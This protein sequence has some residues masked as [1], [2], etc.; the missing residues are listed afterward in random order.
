MSNSSPDHR[1]SILSAFYKI[2]LLQ[3]DSDRSCHIHLHAL[4]CLDKTT[5]YTTVG[6]CCVGLP[7]STVSSLSL[8]MQQGGTGKKQTVYKTEK[9]KIRLE[10]QDI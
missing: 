6:L 3:D 9:I 10:A 7:E 5:T 4:G 2:T 1:S 8:N